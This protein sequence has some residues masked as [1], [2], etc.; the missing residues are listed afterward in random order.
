M[1]Y[2]KE[3]EPEYVYALSRLVF[4]KC[5]AFHRFNSINSFRPMSALKINM[6]KQFAHLF[7]NSSLVFLGLWCSVAIYFIWLPE[8]DFSIYL[9]AGFVLTIPAILLLFPQRRLALGVIILLYSI[10]IASW[11]NMQASNDRDWLPSVAKLPYAVTEG[12]EITVFNIR[13]FDYR[14]EHDFIENY[15]T[16]RYRLDELETLSFILSY[17]DGGTMVAHTI[18]S[19]GFK[20]GD[21]LAVSVETRVA[22]G[23]SQELIQGFF[24]QYEMIYILADERDI[25]RLRTNFRKE[26]VFLYPLRISKDNIRKVFDVVIKRVNKLK[27]SPEFYNTL[28]QNCFTSLRADLSSITRPKNQFDW[29]I[30]ANGYS[31]R[32]V[33]D[34]SDIDTDLS[35]SNAK[36]YFHINQYVSDDNS[37]DYFSTRIRP[38]LLDPAF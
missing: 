25:I 17:W 32:M 29:R 7:L 21:Y 38:N 12:E 20:N 14:T 3:N 36:R 13:N 16:R 31:D 24:N 35:F 27:T 9:S 19:F 8:T 18:L 37:P 1:I 2:L 34:N 5:L 6:L 23:K 28:T 33:Y 30:V 22:Q 15:Y 11:N 4:F 10:V 26:E